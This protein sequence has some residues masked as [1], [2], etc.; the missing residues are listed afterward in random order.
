MKT[1]FRLF[2]LIS[3]SLLAFACEEAVNIEGGGIG[4]KMEGLV[5]SFDKSVIKS[6]G[7]DVVTFSAYYNGENVSD[8][9]AFFLVTGTEYEP[10]NR[11]FSTDK[12]GEYSFQAA[13]KTTYSDV[14]SISAISRDIPAAA[15]DNE[16]GNTSFVRRSFFN[17]HTGSQCP[18]CPFMTHLIR[19][20]LTDDV[21]DKVV[22]ASL[23]NYSGEA[24]FASVPN[25][26]SSWPYLHIDYAE[27]YPYNGSVDGLKAKI[28]DATSKPAM[29]GISASPIYYEDGQII[30]KVAVKA[31]ETA[32]YNVGLWLMQDNFKKT[33]VV[34]NDRLSLLEGTW[35]DSY[36]YHNNSVRVAESKYLGSHVGYPLG[37]IEAGKTA[38]WIFLVTANIG[39]KDLNGDGQCN[40]VDSWWEGKSKVNLDDLHFAAFVTARDGSRYN[41][42]NA[43]DFKYNESKSFEYIK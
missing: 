32:E 39:Q 33:Q 17:Q 27:T 2:I 7:N 29:A 35:G 1:V 26:A 9:V 11:T 24:G 16:K 30:V 12:V 22:L 15:I 40:V 43:I 41:V 3:A 4:I 34:D 18:N 42:V 10:M 28:N 13:Y 21:K 6:D 20:T 5:L 36:H 37:K 25:P 38:E 14:V 19:K 31:A 8:E 23:R